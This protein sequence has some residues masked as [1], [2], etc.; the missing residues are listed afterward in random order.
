MNGDNGHMDAT[1]KS[2]I[3]VRLREYLDGEE[4]ANISH[5]TKASLLS[6][7]E[8][9]IRLGAPPVFFRAEIRTVGT[10]YG[11]SRK[12]GA[13]S[14]R[15]INIEFSIE[16]ELFYEDNRDSNLVALASQ[17]F[18]DG[19]AHSISEARAMAA[20]DGS[21]RARE[22][23]GVA[24]FDFRGFTVDDVELIRGES[25]TPPIWEIRTVRRR[26]RRIG[27][28]YQIGEDIFLAV[29]I[30]SGSSRSRF[31]KRVFNKK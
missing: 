7:D 18:F 23:L 15:I 16:K 21:V 20:R 31:P 28:C 17:V 24:N 25:Y 6:L 9:A 12:R 3:I 11:E 19:E 14:N 2:K 1:L 22:K 29:T 8:D 30:G 13:Q 4:S 27:Y 10:A 5:R 26:S